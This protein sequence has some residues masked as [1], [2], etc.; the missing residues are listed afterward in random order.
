MEALGKQLEQQATLADRQVRKLIDEA[1][2]QGLA[3][4]APTLR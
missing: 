4:P 1:V 3:E 2:R